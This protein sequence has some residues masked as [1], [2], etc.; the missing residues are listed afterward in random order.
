MMRRP[1]RRPSRSRWPRRRPAAPRCR[2]RLTP[3]ET[4]PAETDTKPA[5]QIAE[6][7]PLDTKPAD[8]KPVETKPVETRRVDTKPKTHPRTTTTTRLETH[9]VQ[10][11]PVETK[12]VQA[13]ET[14]PVD[15][16]PKTVDT[17][18]LVSQYKSVGAE[19]KALEQNKGADAASD[20]QSRYRMI[21]IADAMST[22]P[23]RDQAA[24][25]LSKLHGDIAARLK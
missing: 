23:K 5:E 20:L 13:V 7:K 24:A 6:F 2:R 12:P 1:R 16:K 18:A 3:V 17:A 8:T 19:L 10:T 11:N 4:K 9:P 14:K 21:R 15:T 22:Q 25:L